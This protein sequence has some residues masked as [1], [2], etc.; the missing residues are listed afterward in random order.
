M[1]KTVSL[2]DCAELLGCGLIDLCHALD[3]PISG[4]C[5]Q[6]ALDRLRDRHGR[7]PANGRGALLTER[8]PGIHRGKRLL[9]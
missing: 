6:L 2:L 7:S 3:D 8:D 1:E 4:D 5:V 9:G